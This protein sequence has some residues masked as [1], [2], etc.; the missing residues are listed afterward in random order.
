M[1]ETMRAAIQTKIGEMTIDRIE[2]PTAG[3]G[4]VIVRVRAA[5]TCG[6]D[7]KILERGHVRISPPLVMG[8]EFSGDVAEAGDGA[9]FAPGDAVAGGLS[10]P[11]GECP[12]CRSGAENRCDSPERGLAWGAFAEYVRIPESVV[13]R[14]LHRK[15]SG[16]GYEAAALVD[17]LAAVVHGWSRLTAPVDDLLVVGTGAV[18]LLWIA[19][20][21]ARGV[22]RVAALGK[23]DERLRAASTWGARVYDAT[24]GAD[25]PRARTVVECVG[26]PQAWSEAFDLALPGG[27]VLFFGGCAPGA[28]V[29]LDT[30]KLH[31][32]EVRAGGSFHYRPDEAAEALGLLASGAIDPDP[33]F[34]GEGGISD[35]PGFFDRM[36]RSEG[37]KFVVRP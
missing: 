23:G 1:A 26:T 28:A 32:G 14:N 30:E 34:S 16:L 20:A 7:R 22:A 31:Y 13:R 4:E 2:R 18:G 29:T 27:E 33:L 12:A 6:T 37:I 19:L 5:L 25:R 8:H 17:P 24:S 15:P 10:G 9:P 36:R 21:R 3:R 11:C 35:L